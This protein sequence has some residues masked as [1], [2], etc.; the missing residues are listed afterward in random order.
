LHGELVVAEAAGGKVDAFIRKPKRAISG[1]HP[2][3]QILNQARPPEKLVVDAIPTRFRRYAVPM[4]VKIKRGVLR[5]ELHGFR[6]L[7]PW[8]GKIEAWA[9]DDALLCS[10]R[11]L[12]RR[13]SKG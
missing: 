10:C 4:S 5:R 7:A 6:C 13:I 12:E 2:E 1:L 11:K 3:G 9:Q 8:I